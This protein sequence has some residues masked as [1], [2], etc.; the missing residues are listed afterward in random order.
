MPRVELLWWRE[1]PS[2]ERTVELVRAEMETQGLDPDDLVVT[3][4]RTD[5]GAERRRFVGSPTVLVDGADIQPTGDEPTGLTCRVY[6]R[7]NGR[8]SPLPDP[9]DV[10]DAL[11]AAMRGDNQ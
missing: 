2:W 3:E 1:C 7:R 9:E 6:R 8:I 10:R 4:V 11:A 5:D